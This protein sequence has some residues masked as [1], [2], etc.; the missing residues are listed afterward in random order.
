MRSRSF[1]RVKVLLEALPAKIVVLVELAAAVEG[2][3]GD[4]EAV[5]R[6]EHEGLRAVGDALGPQLGVRGALE[7]L[8]VRPVGR[9]HRVQAAAARLKTFLLRLVVTLYQAHELAHAVS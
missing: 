1:R 3:V 5:V 7:A 9:H 6:L 4:G 8:R 2:P